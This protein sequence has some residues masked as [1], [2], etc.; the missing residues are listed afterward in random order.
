MPTQAH[1]ARGYF[2][3]A[4]ATFLWGV[5]ATLGRA[6]FTGRLLPHGQSLRAIDPLILSQSRAT[7]SLLVLLVVLLAVRGPRR[8][9]LPMADMRRMFV[10][11]ILGVAASNYLYYLAIQRTNVATAIILQYTAPVWVLL[12]T[13]A[14]GVQK[15]TLQR[16]AAVGLAVAGIAL[17]IGVFGAG[18]FRLDT[19]GVIAALLAAFSFAFYNVGGHSILARY[20]RWTVLLYTLISAS[21]FWMVVNPPWKIA[22]AHYANSQWLFLLGFSLISVLGPFSF[23]FAGLQHLEPT[24]AIV[25][26]CLEPVFSI[27]IAAVVLGEVLRPLQTLGILLVL[28]AIVV[29]Q[30]PDRRAREPITIVE[31]ID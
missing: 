8:L 7:F 15:P 5:A 26:S 30:W 29:V 10:L 24:R 14:R 16:I 31:P 20:D 3:I 11:G 1:S 12:Y 13:V 18:G 23:Y 28:V 27:V 21:L 22:A 2:Y 19:L 25:V 9:R 4:T 6:A 17:V